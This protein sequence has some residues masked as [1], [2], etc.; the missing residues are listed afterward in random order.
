MLIVSVI[1]LALTAFLPKGTPLIRDSMPR[2]V[3]RPWFPKSW[4]LWSPATSRANSPRNWT[5]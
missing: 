1:F 4:R 2:P 5:R 3:C